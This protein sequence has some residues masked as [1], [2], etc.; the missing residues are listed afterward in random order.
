MS[1][2]SSDISSYLH[3]ERDALSPAPVFD[4]TPAPTRRMS[5]TSG[6][7]AQYLGLWCHTPRW[8]LSTSD[9]AAYLGLSAPKGGSDADSDTESTGSS[10]VM[11]DILD[12][13]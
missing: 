3:G 1:A 11:E 5:V 12:A 7:I 6:D 10:N 2:S 13:Y 4:A 8:N 9:V